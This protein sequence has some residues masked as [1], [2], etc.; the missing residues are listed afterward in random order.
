MKGWKKGIF[1]AF[2]ACMMLL[3][4]GACAERH[5]EDDRAADQLV[6]DLVLEAVF[7]VGQVLGQL[8]RDVQKAVVHAADFNHA[9]CTLVHGLA[10]SKPR[11]R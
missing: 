2:V 4:A 9:A 3:S 11:H 7:E 8:T 1:V 6:L 5:A 10:F